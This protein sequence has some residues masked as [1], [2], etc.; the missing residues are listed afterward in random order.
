MTLT[1]ILA[2][3]AKAHRSPVSG[4]FAHLCGV[5]ISTRPRRGSLPSYPDAARS[6]AVHT[7]WGR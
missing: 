7:A 6:L 5:Q 2:Q 4:A 1:T 3:R